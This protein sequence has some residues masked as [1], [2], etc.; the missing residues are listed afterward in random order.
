MQRF[1][2]DRTTDGKQI[3]MRFE[4]ISSAIFVWS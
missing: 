3:N 2:K 4:L 1:E